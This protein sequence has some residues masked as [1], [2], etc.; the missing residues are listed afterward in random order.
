M[1][2]NWT[3][4]ERRRFQRRRPKAVTE[5]TPEEVVAFLTGTKPMTKTTIPC[6]VAHPTAETSGENIRWMP[7][8]KAK[9]VGANGKIARVTIMTGERVHAI[10]AADEICLEVT[11]DDENDIAF[12]VRAKQLRLV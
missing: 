2:D 10:G 7:G 9:F 3:P 6:Y 5:A 4:S 1:T 12:C 11:F 8:Q